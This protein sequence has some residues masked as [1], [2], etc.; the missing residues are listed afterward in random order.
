MNQTLTYTIGA[1]ADPAGTVFTVSWGDGSSTQTTATTVTHTYTTSAIY[2]VSVTATAAGLSSAPVSGSVD[3]VPVSVAIKADPANA[4]AEML[5]V[6]ST[7]NYENLA[8][9]GSSSS[10]SLVFDG[11]ALGDISPTNG[12]AFALV[13]VFA[14]GAGNNVLNDGLAVS[15]V[16]VGGPGNN[17]LYGGSG[18]SLLIGG[19]SAGTLCAGS[20]G[21]ILIGGVTSYDANTIADQTALAFFMAE[22]DSTSSYSTRVKQLSGKNGSGGLNGSYFLNSTTVFNNNATDW[23]YGDSL[24]AGATL[25]WFFAHRSGRNSDNLYDLAA[26]RW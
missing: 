17:A 21:D 8:V 2:T 10:V 7:A 5:I 16:V 6:A 9:W 3:V 1:G 24:A 4:G 23:L 15:S 14:G 25:D 26:G 20:S 18:R 12:E 22:W 13:E 11:V 19:P